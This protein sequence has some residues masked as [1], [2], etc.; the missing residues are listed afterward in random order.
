MAV[1]LQPQFSSYL[2]DLAEVLDIPPSRYDDAV[3]RYTAVGEWL[4]DPAS[5]LAL[6]MPEIY[7]QGSFGLGTVVKPI[8]DDDHYDI[9]LVCQ[10]Q[11]AQ[12]AITQQ[13]LKAAV[14]DRLKAH[15]IYQR[16]LDVEGR[17]CWTLNY[18]DG[19]RF[20]MDILPAIPDTVEWL[21]ALGVPYA[22]AQHAICITDKDTWDDDPS[23]PKSN[24]KGYAAW[25]RH[26][27]QPIFDQ[28]RRLLAENIKASVDDVPEYRVK[29]PLQRAIQLLK[30]HRD[31]Y[32]EKNGEDKP[33]S[34]I[35]TTLA[36]LAY[37]NQA[38]LHDALIAI[39]GG[40]PNHLQ[41]C[42]DGIWWVANPVNPQEN[43]ADRWQEYPQ[44]ER[45]FRGW[46]QQVERDL[47]QILAASTI[48]GV[49]T[50]AQSI[51]GTRTANEAVL[52]YK[53][54]SAGTPPSSKL[55]LATTVLSKSAPA[56]RQW[57]D[58]R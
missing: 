47:A 23:W 39:I 34:I 26:R 8:G 32:F 57:S 16:L 44:R 4:G 7:P 48:D 25:F 46:L 40:M 18:A 12:T 55:S 38:D 41:Q 49:V 24:P 2:G 19:A 42:D 3:K 15:A 58:R 52:Q 17:R 50:K 53:S 45:L 30:R 21:V 43:F 27:M 31:V 29:T 54:R 9:D 5:P 6:Y 22:F 1:V 36:A 35:L 37:Q 10:L 14:G 11:I 33:T 20:H 56:P 13:H 51:F 28:Q